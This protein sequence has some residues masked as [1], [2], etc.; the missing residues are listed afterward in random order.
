MQNLGKMEK[1]V[2]SMEEFAAVMGI[3]R[4]KAFELTREPGFPTVRLGR[5]IVIP[6]DALKLWLDKQ[7]GNANI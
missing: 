2:L 4:N 5:R 7:A 1:V 3:G 6:V